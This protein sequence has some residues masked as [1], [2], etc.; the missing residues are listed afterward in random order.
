[1][2]KNEYIINQLALGKVQIEVHL[3]EKQWELGQAN[4]HIKLLEE[5]LK[6]LKEPK[7]SD[8]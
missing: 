8:E 3:L 2:E 1:M 6:L 7:G 5:E 4:D